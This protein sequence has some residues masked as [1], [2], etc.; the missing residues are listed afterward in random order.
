M[1]LLV[2]AGEYLGREW[3]FTGRWWILGERMVIYGGPWNIFCGR[4]QR[5]ALVVEE[6]RRNVIFMYINMLYSV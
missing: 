4:K 2:G 6:W 3:L 1:I 5:N